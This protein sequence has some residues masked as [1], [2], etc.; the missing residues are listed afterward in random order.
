MTNGAEEFCFVLACLSGKD[1]ERI[2]LSTKQGW[3]KSI[4]NMRRNVPNSRNFAASILFARAMGERRWLKKCRQ[5]LAVVN[6][7]FGN[8][9]GWERCRCGCWICKNVGNAKM[10]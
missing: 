6:F 4:E 2:C 10:H 3:H 5:S 7:E 1:V 8:G 9:S